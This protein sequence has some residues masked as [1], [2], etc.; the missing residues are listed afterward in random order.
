MA[1]LFLLFLVVW[2]QQANRSPPQ[3][4]A[5][6]RAPHHSHLFMLEGEDP[7]ETVA[8]RLSL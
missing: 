4:H 1:G 5:A 7:R 6:G 2:T 8:M 3:L